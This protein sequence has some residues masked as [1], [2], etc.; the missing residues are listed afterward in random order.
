MRTILTNENNNFLTGLL[1]WKKNIDKAFEGNDECAICYYII[2]AST[3]Q[4][5]ALAWKTCKK[6]LHSDCIRQ[7]FEKSDKIDCPLYR[8]RFL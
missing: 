8:S 6:K 1:M 4:L 7:W 3:R 5:P 2:H